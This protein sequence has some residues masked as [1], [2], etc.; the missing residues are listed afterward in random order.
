MSPL[1]GVTYEE[2]DAAGS[3]GPPLDTATAFIVGQAQK[4]PTD[5]AVFISSPTD[6]EATYGDEFPAGYLPDVARVW[7]KEGGSGIW[8]ARYAGPAKKAASAKFV[9]GVA[10]NTMEVLA[11]NEGEWGNNLKVAVSA[12]EGGSFTITVLYN[13]VAVESER[14]PTV[15]EAHTWALNS[16]YIRI[17]DLG[18]TDPAAAEKSLTGGTDDRVNATDTQR[19]ASLSLFPF[20]LGPGQVLCPGATSTAM[21]TALLE[22]AEDNNRTAILDGADT[23][24]VATLT[25]AAATLRA[26]GT[27]ARC[28]GLFAP[29]AVIP[30]PGGS[31]KTIPYSII[32]AALCARRDLAT[33]D[34]KAG[35]GNPNAP[36]AG[37]FEDAGV[38]RLATRLSQ[39]PWTDAERT[40]LNQAGVNVVRVVYEQ[41]VTYGY[42]TLSNQVTDELNMWLNNRRLDTAIIA[43]AM[44]VG[45]EFNF[46]QV[47]GRGR[48]LN[49]FKAALVG[50]IMLPYLEVGALFESKP[51]AEDAYEVLTGEDVNPPKQLAEGLVKAVIDARRSPPAERVRLIYV[52][53][54]L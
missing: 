28:G 44:A 19:I 31:T 15:A 18:A 53:E 34:S 11:A 20:D 35:I 27:P 29:W 5:R 3:A 9:D 12:V 52:K 23:H 7:P 32:Q 39:D 14:F 17:T 6:Y 45:E 38:S 10:A 4:G 40:T 30:G 8:M 2:Q 48:L 42:H 25:G 49:D 37:V 22:H 43:A 1:P 41:V 51:G 13:G 50:R 54:E 21:Y 46:R 24:T 33:L 16:S 47:D 26:L 36:A